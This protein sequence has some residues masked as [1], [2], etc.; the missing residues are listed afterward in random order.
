MGV[1]SVFL[2]DSW[3]PDELFRDAL[4][5]VHTFMIDML[6][7]DHIIMCVVGGVGVSSR[8]DAINSCLGQARSTLCLP[9]RYHIRTWKTKLQNM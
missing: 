9:G 3:K 6:E 4:H 2:P 7:H 8:T 5:A 1:S